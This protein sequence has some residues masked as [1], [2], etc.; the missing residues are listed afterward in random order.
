MQVLI[1]ILGAS[2]RIVL[3]HTSKRGPDRF[4][5]RCLTLSAVLVVLCYIKCWV[6]SAGTWSA[7]F[8]SAVTVSYSRYGTD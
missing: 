1:E 2:V 3:L 6:L 5:D 8:I 4:V 7:M